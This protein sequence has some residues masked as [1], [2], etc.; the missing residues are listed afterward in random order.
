M[1]TFT[2]S[3]LGNPENRDLAFLDDPPSGLGRSA[4]HLMFG[5]PLT[6]TYPPDAS[7]RLQEQHPGIRLTSLLGNSNSHLIA[8][9]ALVEL[10]RAHCPSSDIE[11][12]PLR[13]L[14]HRGRLHSARYTVVNPL[15]SVDC[16]HPTRGE[17]VR[18]AGGE[19]LRV[20]VMVLDEAKLRDAPSLFRVA[21]EPWTYVVDERLA[22]A[23]MAARLT[24][25]HLTELE[26]A[27]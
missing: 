20:A 9:P 17:V 6:D 21:E 11:Y 3:T 12:L 8:A 26:V 4:A 27:A 2:L 13:V 14:D 22:R 18:D 16:L 24:N 15:G 10:I 23:M 25:I 7:V 1:R 5:L 19:P